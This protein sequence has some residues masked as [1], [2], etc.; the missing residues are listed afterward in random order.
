MG[1]AVIYSSLPILTPNKSNKAV[2]A[3]AQTDL[4][5]CRHCIK[6]LGLKWDDMKYLTNNRAKMYIYNC[7]KC[8]RKITKVMSERI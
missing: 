5:Y 8:G 2:G 4:V 3:I 7:Y 6:L 1:S